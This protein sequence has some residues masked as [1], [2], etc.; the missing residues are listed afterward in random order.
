MKRTDTEIADIYGRHVKMVY[1]VCYSYMKIPSDAED[2]VSD[3]FY[4]LIVSDPV[5]KNAEHE[6]AW[7]VR[8]ASNVCKNSLKHWRRRNEP[9]EDHE[10]LKAETA[11]TNDVWEAVLAL[12]DRYKTVIYLYYYEGY[13]GDEIACILKK[14]AST[15]RNH[16]REARALLRQKLGDEFNG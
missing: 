5:F 13:S 9:L 14:P 7:L 2:A 4:K 3:T 6:K 15:V 10:E 16:L 8:T 1:R 11:E 12:P